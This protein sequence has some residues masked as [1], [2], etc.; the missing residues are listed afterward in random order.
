[1]IEKTCLIY[2]LCFFPK[3]GAIFRG[4]SYFGNPSGPN[5]LP[6]NTYEIQDKN[7]TG[8]L[9]VTQERECLPVVE[10]AYGTSDTPSGPGKYMYSVFCDMYLELHW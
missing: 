7:I 10:L 4:S 5:S 2:V 8:Y 3:E 6:L 9:S 1:M